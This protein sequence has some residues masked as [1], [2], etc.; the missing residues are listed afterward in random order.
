MRAALYA[1][2]STLDQE[3][4]NQATELRTYAAAR[5]WEVVEYTDRG[6]SGS[7]DRR[8][9]LDR[10]V[11]DAKRRKVDT[12]VVWRLDR[13]GRSLR[14]LVTLLDELHAI[15]VG[16]VSLGE[17]IDLQTRAGRLQLHILAALAQF[18]RERIAERVR[19]GLARAKANRRRLGQKPIDIPAADLDRTAHLSVRRAAAELG[20]PRSVLHRARLSRKPWPPRR[21]RA[22]RTALSGR[23]SVSEGCS[24]RARRLARHDQ[25]LEAE[26]T[27]V[28][29]DRSPRHHATGAGCALGPAR[30]TPHAALDLEP[31][32]LS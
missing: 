27:R 9:A 14:H 20:V 24:C 16:F 31:P 26:S 29:D 4:E 2:V 7:T 23:G 32:G 5:G 6:I 1:R 28:G 3:P 13:L 30:V 8:P 18:E 21:R 10:L 17:G 15:G 22:V 25:A 12:V 11:A 19:A